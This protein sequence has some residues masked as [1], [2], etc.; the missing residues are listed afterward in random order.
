[1]QDALCRSP[2]TKQAPPE[3]N[4]PTFRPSTEPKPQLPEQNRWWRRRRLRSKPKLSEQCGGSLYG[5][6]GFKPAHGPAA[7]HT[8]IKICPEHMSQQP[9]PAFTGRASVVSLGV[10]L[11]EQKLVARSRRRR[12]TTRWIRAKRSALAPAPQGAK[13]PRKARS[14]GLRS[15]GRVGVRR[16]RP[17]PD[18]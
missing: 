1:M 12:S 15:A 13:R 17:H 2:S 4:K 3:G 8:S 14:G 10:G 9:G 16:V 6:G 11:G 7:V 18:P 5:G